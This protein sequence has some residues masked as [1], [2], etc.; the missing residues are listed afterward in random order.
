M[1]A[2]V[3]EHIL[4]EQ[5][6]AT[7]RRLADLTRPGGILVVTTPNNEDLELGMVYC[8]V[9]NTLFHRWQHVRSFTDISLAA[10]LAQYGFEAL[11]THHVEFNDALY[12]P[13]DS[14]WGKATDDAVLPSHI[15]ELRANRSVRIGGETNLLYVG[16][17]RE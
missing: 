7:L 11:V 15:Q 14:L 5:L 16:R 17:R 12:V 6:D 13:S 10:L 4:D 8:P 1:M 2:E 9:S 3:I